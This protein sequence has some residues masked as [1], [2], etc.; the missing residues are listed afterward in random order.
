[1]P[2]CKYCLKEVELLPAREGSKHPNIPVEKDPVYF[3]MVQSHSDAYDKF[4]TDDGELV[5][6]RELKPFDMQKTRGWIP[7]KYKC[8][9]WKYCNSKKKGY[10]K[11]L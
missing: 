4:Y 10:R 7:H 9:N 3:H 11:D 5:Y 8:E 6:G 2:I 1:M